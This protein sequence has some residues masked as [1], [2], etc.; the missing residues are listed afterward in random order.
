VGTETL[1]TGAGPFQA[2]RLRTALYDE[3]GRPSGHP[4]HLWISDTPS[5]VPVK[6]Q[7]E[8]SVGSFILTLSQAKLGQ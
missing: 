5:R 4:I 1:Q 6:L 8:L 3:T 7:S 2:F